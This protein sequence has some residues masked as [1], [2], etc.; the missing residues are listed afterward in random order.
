MDPNKTR[1]TTYTGRCFCGAVEIAVTGDPVAM[2][3]S[4]VQPVATGVSCD[5]VNRAGAVATTFALPGPAVTVANEGTLSLAP[6]SLC[7]TVT[8]H[9]T[10]DSLTQPRSCW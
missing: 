3:L 6:F 1:Q 7:M 9:W 10:D 5:G 2:G 8:V 4:V